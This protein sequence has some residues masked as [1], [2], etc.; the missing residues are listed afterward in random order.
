[1]QVVKWANLY[2]TTLR[3]VEDIRFVMSHSAVPK[4]LCQ[5]RRDLVRAWMRLLAS[6]QGMNTL[7]RETSSHIED[8]NE[9]VHLPFVLCHSISNIL[10]LQ[11]TGAFSASLNDDT[12]D[13]TYFSMYKQDHEDQ[14]SLRHAKV[15]R[16]SQ[17]SSVSST[18]GKSAVDHEVKA[19]D[20]FPVPSSALWLVYEC[21]RSL[22]SWLGLDNT[23]GPLSA[24]SLKT[25]D[26]PDGS[27]NNFL[28][29]KR[30]LSRFRRGRYIF[31][32]TTSGS[33]CT[34]LIEVFTK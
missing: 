13:E 25:S 1:M 10:S 12:S 19:A 9:N 22:E 11:V 4:Y 17:E 32:P 30:T 26:G 27:S 7:K 6:V 16:L 34:N 24:L 23:L 31:K 5:R 14:D 28:V 3:V 21:L 18:T 33:N 29:L 2:E 20:N 8:E 15:G